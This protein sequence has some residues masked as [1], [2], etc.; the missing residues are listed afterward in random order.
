VVEKLPHRDVG[1]ARVGQPELRQV[2]DDR[3]VQRH[4]AGVHELQNSQGG[5]RLA[6]RSDAEATVLGDRDVVGVV[7]VAADVQDLLPSRDGD[8][9]SRD[10]RR[11]QLVGH[12]TVNA[13]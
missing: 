3:I 1:A 2:R 6:Q 4:L 7:P 10:G 8:R 5:E 12:Q 11:R 9:G 13:G